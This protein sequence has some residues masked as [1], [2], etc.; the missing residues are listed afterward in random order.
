MSDVNCPYCNAEIDIC[1]D[2]GQGYSEDVL[3]NQQCSEC[4]KYFVFNTAISFDYY[5]EKADCLNGSDHVWNKVTHY[6]NNWPEW[7]RC[8][9]CEEEIRGKWV[10]DAQ[11]LQREE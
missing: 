1:H 7:K 2:D 8:E 6:P 5:P 9:T 4:E 3:H 11:P 10:K